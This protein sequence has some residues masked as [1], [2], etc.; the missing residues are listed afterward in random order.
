MSNERLQ[1]MKKEK[2]KFLKVPWMQIKPTYI[3]P[4]IR[5]KNATS[6]SCI[7]PK[8]TGETTRSYFRHS[9]IQFTEN[10]HFILRK[11]ESDNKSTEEQLKLNFKITSRR[12]SKLQELQRSQEEEM[13]NINLITTKKKESSTFHPPINEENVFETCDSLISFKSLNDNEEYNVDEDSKNKEKDTS[14]TLCVTSGPVTTNDI[15][16]HVWIYSHEECKTS[17]NLFIPKYFADSI[18]EENERITINKAITK[19]QKKFFSAV[20]ECSNAKKESEDLR[21][22]LNRK[23]ERFKEKLENS[24]SAMKYNKYLHQNNMEIPDYIDDLNFP[25]N[26]YLK[27]ND[28]Y[29]RRRLHSS[30]I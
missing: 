17:E 1:K 12:P 25:A 15:K 13:K 14:D 30:L 11:A 24:Y 3:K 16:D 5:L 27:I 9:S 4:T 23:D 19:G 18:I 22:L 26:E 21:C 6:R 8:Q 10:E 20:D 28:N 7:I 2:L 29:K